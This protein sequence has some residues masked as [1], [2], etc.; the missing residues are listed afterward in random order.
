MPKQLIEVW[1]GCTCLH[2]GQGTAEIIHSKG[3]PTDYLAERTK[4]RK[5]RHEARRWRHECHGLT[6]GI[7]LHTA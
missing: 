5:K 4:R 3:A 2:D 6:P 7:E 1:P